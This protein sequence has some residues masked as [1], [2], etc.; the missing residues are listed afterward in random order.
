MITRAKAENP[1][2]EQD[3]KFKLSNFNNFDGEGVVASI[4]RQEDPETLTSNNINVNNF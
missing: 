4:K 3:T 2:T 1:S